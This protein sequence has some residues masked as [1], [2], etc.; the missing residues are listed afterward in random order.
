MTYKGFQLQTVTVVDVCEV[1][2]FHIIY[3]EILIRF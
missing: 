1:L 3:V 2:K